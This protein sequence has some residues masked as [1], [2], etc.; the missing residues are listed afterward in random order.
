MYYMTGFADEVSGDVDRQIAALQ[1]L[2]W[3]NLESRGIFG[4]KNI[5]SVSDAEFEEFQGKLKDAGIA[6]NCYG[7]G[8]ANWSKHITES[9]DSSYEE[10]AKAI[11]RLQKLGTRMVRVMSFFVPDELKSTSWELEEEV[12][13][14]MKHLVSM[15]EDAGL[16]LVHE[17][18]RNWGGLSFE[19]TLR[20][21]DRIQ[22]P[23]FKLVFDT[24]NPVFN[25][26]VRGNPPYKRQSSWEFYKNV[27]EFVSY[28]HIK[29]GVMN[30][31]KMEFC[32]AGEGDGD[33]V[34]IFEDLARSG[35]DG[36]FSI[37][38]HMGAVF[39]D[40]SVTNPEQ[41][42]FDVFVEYGQ[43]CEAMLKAAYGKIQ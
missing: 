11:P 35:Y 4:N 6:V 25:D 32:F 18:C 9:P 29:D 24:G 42:K 33:A 17:N 43:R 10:L 27:R 26:D 38:P 1:K 7:S 22:S 12:V 16:L 40:S 36:G 15:A 13:K 14:R 41:Y 8:I 20:L 23:A 39:H 30:G 31:D 2:G 37:E 28:V 34:K 21:L 5:A 19:H 3:K